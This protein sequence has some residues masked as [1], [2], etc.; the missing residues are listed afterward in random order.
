MG[1]A[2]NQARLLTL[3][4]RMHDLELTSMRC[5]NEK[6]LLTAM[7]NNIAIKYNNMLN[8]ANNIGPD[9][10]TTT[11]TT[12][13]SRTYNKA[14]TA[15]TAGGWEFNISLDY[16]NLRSAGYEIKEKN[17]TA[18][19]DS[20]GS[21]EKVW[22]WYTTGGDAWQMPQ[23]VEELINLLGNKG[24]IDPNAGASG[25][26]KDGTRSTTETTYQAL[27]GFQPE[28]AQECEYLKYYSASK[29]AKAFATS[30]TADTSSYNAR[31]AFSQKKLEEILGSMGKADA[32]PD[33]SKVGDPAYGYY[34]EVPSSSLSPSTSNPSDS[35]KASSLLDRCKTDAGLLKESIINGSIIL[36][37]DGQQLSLSDVAT[38]NAGS[39]ATEGTTDTETWTETS[40]I[41]TIDYSR[42][43]AARQ[44]AKNYYDAETGKMTIKEKGLDLRQKQAET[45]YSAACTEYESM[46]SLISENAERGFSLFG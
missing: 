38:Y 10:I 26:N 40:T 42:R 2:A 35:T 17:V 41:Q 27:V 24:V 6:I 18:N 4:S 21:T 44:A 8:D 31:V 9:Y 12:N 25:W 3:Q 20:T 13:G 46:K 34:E 39:Q 23:T 36:S 28:G 14:G 15:G 19:T 1:L 45:E 16:N 22:K 7:S 5:T 11:N 33:A 30:S 32:T 29:L 37:K 43:D